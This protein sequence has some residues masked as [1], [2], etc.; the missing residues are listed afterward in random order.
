METLRKKG[1]T[2]GQGTE[3]ALDT[4]FCIGVKG[5]DTLQA[6][7]GLTVKATV[8]GQHAGLKPPY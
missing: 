2:S 4:V 1:R 8:E 7:S 5:K 3:Q 6:V